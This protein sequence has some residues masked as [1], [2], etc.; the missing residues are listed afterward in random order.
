MDLPEIFSEPEIGDWMTG[1][2]EPAFTSSFDWPKP[3]MS[4][5]APQAAVRMVT[6]KMM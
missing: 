3:A 6:V 2:E 5:E 1:R 4:L